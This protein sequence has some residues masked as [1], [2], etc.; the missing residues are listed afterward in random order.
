MY[1]LAA[2]IRAR[3]LCIGYAVMPKCLLLNCRLMIYADDLILWVYC[4]MHFVSEFRAM[5]QRFN[6]ILDSQCDIV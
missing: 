3:F 4:D 2:T 1:T 6:L 5:L